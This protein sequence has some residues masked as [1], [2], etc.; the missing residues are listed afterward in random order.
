MG[1]TYVEGTNQPDK[2]SGLDHLP[3]A[4]AYMVNWLMP[5][6]DPVRRVKVLGV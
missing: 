3:D 5:M 4:C 6:I 2:K 1:L